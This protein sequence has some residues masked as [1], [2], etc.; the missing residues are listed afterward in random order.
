MK[1][2]V[3]AVAATRHGRNSSCILR[4]DGIMKAKEK[5][6]YLASARFILV[7]GHPFASSLSHSFSPFSFPLSRR[8]FRQESQ[9]AADGL[10]FL[11]FDY[12][13]GSLYGIKTSLNTPVPTTAGSVL[14]NKALIVKL[15]KRHGGALPL[16]RAIV[17]RSFLREEIRTIDCVGW[18]IVRMIYAWLSLNEL[19]RCRAFLSP[20]FCR[21][22]FI[23]IS[24]RDF[25]FLLMTVSGRYVLS[26]PRCCF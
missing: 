25:P 20:R 9:V 15:I 23:M 3:V 22:I 21:C 16:Q 8:P 17:T 7:V 14:W 26:T 12:P 13:C 11:S 18:T 24:S 4:P 2:R 1:K 5:S 6:V 10:L 19:D